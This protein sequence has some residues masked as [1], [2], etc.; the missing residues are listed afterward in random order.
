MN[1]ARAV[2]AAAAAA[3][4]AGFGTLA[5]LR[6]RSFE[7]GRFDL[8]NMAQ[9]VWSTADG[10]PLEVTSLAG[11]QF[12]RLGA[13]FN[14]ALVLLAP[15]WAV[16]P[17]PEML[18]VAQA[19]GLAL[20]A[21]AV[22]LLAR[23]H[24]R[25]ETAA[26]LLSVAYLV[27]PALGWMTLADFH[28]VAL[29]TPLLLWAFWFLDEERL[30]PFALAAA[31]AVA[32]KEHVGLAVAGM[33]V[34]HAIARRRALPGVP[35]AAVGLAIALAAVL[36]VVP[37]FSP[38]GESGF[39][40]RYERVGGSPGGM[41]RTAVEDPGKVAGAA[42]EG[43]DL[44]Y[45]LKLLVP[46]AGMSLAAPAALL[47]AL[48]E[49]ALNVL[50]ETLTQT[51]IRYQYS[52]TALAALMAAAIFGLRRVSRRTG[53][54][55]TPLAAA[56]TA[57]AVGSAY[58]LGPLPI[59]QPLP[60]GE[61]LPRRTFQATEHDRLAE[62]ALHLI[63][64]EAVVSAS[65][66]LGGHLS[67]RRRILS[68]PRLLDATWVAVDRTSPGYLDRIAPRPYAQAIARLEADPRW[69]LVFD[70]DGVLVFRRR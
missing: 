23:K 58:A 54:P 35:I 9:A 57:A 68:F 22:F 28:A 61:G 11:E 43:R 37:H 26:A 24:L 33:G 65:N 51:S 21:P 2:A 5:V 41:A 46:L 10:D 56:V 55:V 45:L 17:S 69:Q 18:L 14:P 66:S 1:P 47:V 34:W 39:Y 44:G 31:L 8:G 64:D 12:V 42:T 27:T 49:L 40:G 30:L 6:H 25:S 32:T 3:F 52:A 13:H 38:T 62:T 20:G 70:R 19:V 50:S 48:P 59:F 36:L 53:L 63:P 67:D 29:A 60:G 15:L 7:S 4:A 16:W